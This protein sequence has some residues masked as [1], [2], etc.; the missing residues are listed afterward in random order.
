MAGT[1]NLKENAAQEEAIRTIKG[2]VL[3]ISCPGSGKTTTL[4]RRIH[5]MIESGIEPKH[6]LM[7]TFTNAAAQEMKDKYVSFYQKNPG[8]TFLTIHSLCFN[9]LRMEGRCRPDDLLPAREAREYFLN[10]LEKCRWIN[11][12][13]ELSKAIMTEISMIRN[14]Y[15]PI[16]A[17]K[18]VSVSNPLFTK[19][20]Y[21]YA[22]FKTQRG[23]I[24]FDDMLFDCKTM[25]ENSPEILDKWRHVFTYI[26][27]D[28]YQDT[29]RV[30]R[31]I[32]YLLAGE[33]GNLCVVGD[34]DQSIYRF[35]GA[36]PSIMLH[37]PKDFPNARV[38][39]M[40]TNYRSG[41][42]IVQIARR[43]IGQNQNRFDKNF[44][45]FRGQEMNF[46]GRVIY[47]RYHSR[48]EEIDG[49]IRLI[50]EFAEKGVPYKEMAV[51]FRTNQQA[52][53]PV[54][55]IRRAEIPCY[56]T[57]RVT[58]LY[59]GWMF[60]DFEAYARLAMGE[61]TNSDLLRVLNRPQRYLK[62]SAFR[63]VEFS[64]F[65]LKRAIGYLKNDAYWKYKA[66]DDRINDWIDI[67]GPG[68][69]KRTDPPSKLFKALT[70]YGGLKYN[71]YLDNYATFRNTDPQEF[72]AIL[73]QL[74]SD[75]EQFKTIG[76][77]FDYAEKTKRLFHEEQKK[78]DRNGVALTTMHKA[79]GL[80]WQVVFI[81]DINEHIVPLDNGKDLSE[82]D[83]EEERRLFYVAMTRAKDA[84]YLMNSDR[85]ESRFMREIKKGSRQK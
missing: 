71:T 84:L 67:L 1:V 79:K 26:Q 43:I 42:S 49:V 20:Y 58:S 51:L 25:L 68:T 45:S 5:H 2:P 82:E 10:E 41:M 4:I 47:Q 34:D 73:D 35:R 80:E 63:N 16:S 52:E 30:Q 48:K 17:Y 31:D 77:W 29:N 3:I 60:A 7:V 57:E 81:I 44:V 19:L 46:Y 55:M 27:C 32:L 22:E 23:K 53:M 15:V 54:T 50:R 78:K 40:S 85:R 14:N 21:G 24:D 9:L 76:E 8:V 39:R 66:A 28:E 56:T 13:W 62:E 64:R 61:G 6:I 18:P 74:K 83:L 33:T 37:F 11:E 75:A 12:P 70:G 38:I 69:L 59:D 36:D 65:A 72:T